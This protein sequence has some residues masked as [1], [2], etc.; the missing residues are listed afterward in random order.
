SGT[1]SALAHSLSARLGGLRSRY[2]SRDAPGEA[3][4]SPEAV[5]RLRAL[6]YL[7]SRGTRAN[8]SE[9]GPD[10]KDR[11]RQYEEYGQALIEASA[12]HLAAA[13]A[14]MQRLLGGDAGLV[15]VRLS[16]GLNEQKLGHHEQAAQ[17]F[18]RV[19][20]QDPLNAL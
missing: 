7:S 13:G 1:K 18:E 16:L 9:S 11:I 3:N 12:G 4:L 14:S 8:S 19:L 5:E 2:P 20:R 6:G 17:A 15:D 10:P